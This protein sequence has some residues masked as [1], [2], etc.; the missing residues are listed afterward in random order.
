[1]VVA[2]VPK[3]RL[4]RPVVFLFVGQGG[5]Y[6]GMGMGLRKAGLLAKEKEEEAAQPFGASSSFS[7]SSSSSSPVLRTVSLSL[8]IADALAAQLDDPTSSTPPAAQR[9]AWATPW[10]SGPPPRSA[11]S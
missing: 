4:S 6:D 11:A 9:P 8:A 1:M 2:A 10:A 7:S 3:S 5:A